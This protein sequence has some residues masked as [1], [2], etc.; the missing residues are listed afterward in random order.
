MFKEYQ[1]IKCIDASGLTD[2]LVEGELYQFHKYSEY[3]GV[4]DRETKVHL[5]DVLCSPIGVR[6]SRFIPATREEI[7]DYFKEKINHLNQCFEEVIK[8]VD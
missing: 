3:V 7:Y 5:Y 6:E 8:L 1:M 4:Y 2:T